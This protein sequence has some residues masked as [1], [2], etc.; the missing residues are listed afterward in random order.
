MYAVISLAALGRVATA[1]DVFDRHTHSVLKAAVK[2]QSPRMSLGL[3]EA[4][5]LKTLG[6]SISSPCIMLQTNDG[7]L[8][9]A[10]VA[11]GFRRGADGPIPVVLI[12]RYVTWRSDRPEATAAAGRDVMLFA[13]FSFNFDI[14]QIVPDGQGGDLTLSEKATLE[15]LDRA[16][17]FALDGSVAPEPDE[18]DSTP[19]DHEGVL[20][21]DYAG[22]WNVNIDGRWRGE[23]EL[24]LRGNGRVE[25][26]YLSEETRSR[27]PLSGRIGQLPNRLRLAI[28]LTNSA[29]QVDALIWTTDK[30]TMAGSVTIAGRRFGFC[31]IRQKKDAPSSATASPA[32]PRD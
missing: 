9:V 6:S 12:E 30:S 11:W 15:P 29:Q 24:K 13:G 20:P 19:D 5:R 17:L 3:D 31:A 28:E 16:K 18:A 22:T 4:V 2:S 21:T 27:Y 10:L 1:A 25:G 7:N 32:A 23:W 26:T 14:G 8:A